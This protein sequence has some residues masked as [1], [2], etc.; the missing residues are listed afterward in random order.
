[1]L[2]AHDARVHLG[3]LALAEHPRSGVVIGLKARVSREHTNHGVRA[4]AALDYRADRIDSGRKQLVGEL[5][6]EYHRLRARVDVA[7][8]KDSSPK[9]ARSEQAKVFDTHRPD[10]RVGVSAAG[11]QLSAAIRRD[12]VEPRYLLHRVRPREHQGVALRVADAQMIIAEHPDR[13]Q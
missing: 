10:G 8:E 6:A 4:V 3:R 13:E 12:R 5:L 9:N 7:L 2:D 11:D 1:M